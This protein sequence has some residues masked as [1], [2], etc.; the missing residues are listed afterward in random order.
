MVRV[1]GEWCVVYLCE[2]IPQRWNPFVLH[3]LG[4]WGEAGAVE[5]CACTPLLTTPLHL[6][7]HC[8]TPHH[9]TP[10][11]TTPHSTPHTTPPHDDLK[12]WQCWCSE[13]WSAPHNRRG[14]AGGGYTTTRAHHLESVS[15]QRMAGM[16]RSQPRP[17]ASAASLL[18]QVI[19]QGMGRS[20]L[21]S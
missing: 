7:Q 5:S 18:R 8:T 14:K 19:R 17:N 4:S 20:H 9:T 15:L 1:S 13:G 3:K 2:C 10:H 12:G 21:P 11:H 6:G 16:G